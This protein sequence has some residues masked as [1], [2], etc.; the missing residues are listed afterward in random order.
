MLLGWFDSLHINYVNAFMGSCVCNRTYVPKRKPNS[1]ID[2]YLFCISKQ[3][4]G[5]EMSAQTCAAHHS[6]QL[7]HTFMCTCEWGRVEIGFDSPF[8]RTKSKLKNRYAFVFRQIVTTSLPCSLNYR[9]LYCSF[10]SER[11]RLSHGRRWNNIDGI[12]SC[13]RLEKFYH[14]LCVLRT[15]WRMH[16]MYE[17]SV[18]TNALVRTIARKCVHIITTWASNF[19]RFTF[20]FCFIVI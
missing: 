20:C 1:E 3:A 18:A 15:L 16:D 5:I 11:D 12:D 8:F 6:R 10:G 2:I 4:V 9:R 14:R 17:F 7:H 19:Q 13:S